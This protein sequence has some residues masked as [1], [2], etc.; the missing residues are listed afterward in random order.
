MYSLLFHNLMNFELRGEI[1]KFFKNKISWKS[2]L[3]DQDFPK[4]MVEIMAMIMV[5]FRLLTSR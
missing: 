4:S 3:W 5:A 1:S 2:V